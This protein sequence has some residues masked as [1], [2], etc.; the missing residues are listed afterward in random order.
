MA[1]L[2]T[3][4]AGY[5]GSHMV[6]ELLDRQESVVVLDNLSTGLRSLV[7]EGAEFVQGDAG[8]I[9][10]VSKIISDYS[11]DSVLHFAGSVVAPESVEQPLSYYA[12]NTAVSRALIEACVRNGV[13]H[14]MFSSSAAVYGDV[15]QSQVAEDTPARPIS[16]YGRSKLMTEW[17]L[18]DAAR[19]HDFRYVSL[20]YFNVAGA[21]PLGRTGPSAPNVTHLIRRA[22]A[23][24]LG[25]AEF[26]DIYGTDY[27]TPDGTGVRDYI[28]VSDLVSVHSLAL[29]SLR[30]GARS[31]TFNCGYGF[32]FS[33]NEVIKVAEAVTKRKILVRVKQRRPGDLASVVADPAKLKS[34]MNWQ[35]RFAELE[36]IVRTAFEWEKNRC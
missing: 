22:C 16:P 7:G 33:V 1:V 17:I 14:F 34:A 26:L 31:N 28:H 4:G 19:A 10:T 5:I 35:P 9:D 12:N 23:V 32:G 29:D 11:V 15:D 36:V 2:V 20:R 3:G 6:Y 27:P 13:E 21:D 8:D 18:E 25:R 24:A 30:A